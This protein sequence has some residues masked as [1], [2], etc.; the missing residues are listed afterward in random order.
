MFLLV[1][2]FTLLSLTLLFRSLGYR[3]NTSDSIPKGLYRITASQ[4]AKGGYVIFCPDTHN[5]F[6]EAVKR[7]YIEKGICP[8]GYGY[9]MKKIVAARGDTVSTT[10]AGIVIN[11]KILA[12]SSPKFVDGAHRTLHPWQ[13]TLY[14]LKKN[15]L[16]TMTDQDEWSFDGRYYG[17]IKTN[18][19]KGMITPIWVKPMETKSDVRKLKSHSASA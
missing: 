13:V 14:T 9:M 18:Q 2:F 6:K 5:S 3:I 17:L 1:T 16:L 15:E 8:S 19:V 12:F 4:P 7:G 10:K 11:H